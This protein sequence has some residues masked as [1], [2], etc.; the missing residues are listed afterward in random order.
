MLQFF[1]SHEL[2]LAH[3]GKVHHISVARRLATSNIQR[4]RPQ[5]SSTDAL[6]KSRQ[7]SSYI[8]YANRPARSSE[9]YALQYAWNL[10]L[11]PRPTLLR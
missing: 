10:S 8:A 3:D 2:P 6:Q 4:L 11:S 9:Q 5:A 7:D 1:C